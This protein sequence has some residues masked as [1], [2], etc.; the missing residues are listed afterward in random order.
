MG[1]DIN[2]TR[3]LLYKLHKVDLVSSNKR[4]DMQKGWYI[5]YWSFKKERVKD[6]IRTLEIS[7]LE[8]SK[9][10]LQKFNNTIYFCCDK[11]CVSVDFD[12]AAVLISGA[13][14]AG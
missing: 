9:E 5:Y 11:L 1:E 10:R 7:R 4:K 2:T 12:Q 3:S 14:S 8:K 13:L 6:I